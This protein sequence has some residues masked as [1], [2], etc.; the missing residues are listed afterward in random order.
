MHTYITDERV[1]I[2]ASLQLVVSIS[3]TATRV[4]SGTVCKIWVHAGLFGGN[5]TGGIVLK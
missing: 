1:K 3:P 4:V 5:S 2:V